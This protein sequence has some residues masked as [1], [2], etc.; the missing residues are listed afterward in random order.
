MADIVP[1]RIR[2]SPTEIRQKALQTLLE[3]YEERGKLNGTAADWFKQVWETGTEDGVFSMWLIK[4]APTGKETSTEEVLKNTKGK[5]CLVKFVD[6]AVTTTS[7]NTPLTNFMSQNEGR[8]KVIIMP[9]F[10]RK[11]FEQLM[12][13][14]NVEVFCETELL[15]NILKDPLQPKFQLLTNA[16]ATR[17]RREYV[18]QPTKIAPMYEYDPVAIALGL[19]H[20]NML[21]IIV[22]NEGSGYIA[23]YRIVIRTAAGRV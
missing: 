1:L 16:E 9:E 22:A 11:V 17:V 18:L 3:Y 5:T 4:E 2:K 21:R 8:R 14:G 13:Y 7:G 20:T 10:N 19:R 23:N 6:E 15:H 12:A